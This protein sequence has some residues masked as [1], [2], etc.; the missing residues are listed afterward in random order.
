M[1]GVGGAG[2]A[3]MPAM[4]F[5]GSGNVVGH[6]ATLAALAGYICWLI[7]LRSI[8]LELR[9]PE[10]AQRII[11]YIIAALVFGAAAFVMFI[12]ILIAGVASFFGAAGASTGAGAAGALGAFAIFA[13]IMCVLIALGS[14]ARYVWYILLVT[15]VRGL[16]DRHLMRM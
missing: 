13:I 10:V 14:L 12:I 1:G 7:Y 9:G 15:Q 4:I 11:Y 5:S 2:P 16:V 3:G 8:A 6:V